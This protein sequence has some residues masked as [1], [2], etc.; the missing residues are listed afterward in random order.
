VY[1]SKALKAATAR[2]LKNIAPVPKIL[3]TLFH[4]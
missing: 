2:Q 1:I 4:L 3:K